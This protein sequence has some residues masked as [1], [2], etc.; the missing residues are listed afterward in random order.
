MIVIVRLL[1]MLFFIHKCGGTPINLLNL[2]Y[3]C[4]RVPNLFFSD[5]II[6]FYKLDVE[7]NGQYLMCITIH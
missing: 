3:I 7:C 6:L 5:K 1:L 4:N 2:G